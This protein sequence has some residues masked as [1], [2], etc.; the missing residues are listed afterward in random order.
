[1]SVNGKTVSMDKIGLVWKGALL[2]CMR[3]SFLLFLDEEK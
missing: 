2:V 3:L 1:M